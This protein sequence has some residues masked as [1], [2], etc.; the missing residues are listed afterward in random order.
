MNTSIH[1]YIYTFVHTYL[2]VNAIPQISNLYNAPGTYGVFDLFESLYVNTETDE[3]IGNFVDEVPESVRAITRGAEMSTYSE[4]S[5][6]CI[7]IKVC[8]Y[9]FLS[10][11]L[12][13]PCILESRYFKV[14]VASVDI[15]GKA[16]NFTL[17]SKQVIRAVN[18]LSL[19][20]AGL[21]GLRGMIGVVYEMQVNIRH[22]KSNT[23]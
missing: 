2:R 5:S 4:T 12:N 8:P 7:D 16:K 21:N 1:L 23:R 19:I 14:P 17:T 15:I 9:N 22:R 20:G 3:T 11:L 18:P 10:M 6:V 13:R